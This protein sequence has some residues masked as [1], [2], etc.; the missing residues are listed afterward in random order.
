MLFS[1]QVIAH[2]HLAVFLCFSHTFA[3]NINNFLLVY[4]FS[5]PQ[6]DLESKLW[7]V[8]L[9]S[10]AELHQ[11]ILPVSVVSAPLVVAKESDKLWFLDADITT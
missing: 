8:P 11:V 9:S 3:N 10:E 2:L 6:Q 5:T 7:W 4:P 1:Y